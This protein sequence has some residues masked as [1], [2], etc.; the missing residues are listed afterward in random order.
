MKVL[1]LLLERRRRR[2]SD[3][4]MGMHVEPDGTVRLS[5]WLADLLVSGVRPKAALSFGRAFRRA[6]RIGKKLEANR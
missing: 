5:Q 6:G 2:F 1:S 4:V 3:D